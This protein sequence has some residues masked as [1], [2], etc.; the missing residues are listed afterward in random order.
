ML[1]ISLKAEPGDYLTIARKEKGSPN[2]FIGAITDEQA[3]TTTGSLSFLVGGKNYVATIYRDA[4][5]A[6]WEKNPHAY[7]IEKF[8]V[9]NKTVFKLKLAPGGGAAVSIIPATANEIKTFKKYK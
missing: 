4:A 7:T 1:R 5:D 6:D 9:D 2:W 3:R 8:I